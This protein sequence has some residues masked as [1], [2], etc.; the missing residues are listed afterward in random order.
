MAGSN[1][2]TAKKGFGDLHETPPA[3]T[4]ALLRVEQLPHFVWD[5][6][7]GLGAIYRELVASE[8]GCW[9]SDIVNFAWQQD[10]IGDFF[11]WVSPPPKVTAIVMN[12]PYDQ[13]EAFV[14]HALDL[15]PEV[16]A[17]LRLNWLAALRQK[18]PGI[19][20]RLARVHVFTRR[21]PLMHRAGWT[22]KRA[23]SQIDHAWFCWGPR[24]P[25]SITITRLDWKGPDDAKLSRHR[26]AAR[27]GAPVDHPRPSLNGANR[28][29]SGGQ[30]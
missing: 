13:A 19:Y 29:L 17:L 26:T 11:G 23:A 10:H 20:D 22:G 5:P 28:S 24:P 1:Q 3:A 30:S 2:R 21:L 12:P 4:Q 16:Y 25:Q 7:C 15:V 18:H 6:C 8:R 14:A 27:T 9:T